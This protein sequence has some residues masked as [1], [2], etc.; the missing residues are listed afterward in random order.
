MLNK[1]FLIMLPII[2]NITDSLITFLQAADY[3]SEELLGKG[4][5]PRPTSG[6]G[7]YINSDN[8]SNMV[9][10]TVMFLHHFTVQ[11]VR[12][13]TINCFYSSWSFTLLLYFCS[14]LLVLGNKVQQLPN[15]YSYRKQKMSIFMRDNTMRPQITLIHHCLYFARLIWSTLPTISTQLL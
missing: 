11:A 4:P 3:L 6:P 1:C 15:P 14:F 8:A 13:D 7:A 9:I 12:L 5:V 2:L 10:L